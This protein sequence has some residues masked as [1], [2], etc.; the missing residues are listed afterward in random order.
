MK[1]A[2]RIQKHT[3]VQKPRHSTCIAYPHCRDLCRSCRQKKK[4][5]EIKHKV[6]E[7]GLLWGPDILGTV[8]HDPSATWSQ[9]SWNDLK[10][11]RFQSWLLSYWK[12]CGCAFLNRDQMQ[13][14]CPPLTFPAFKR[15][16]P[17]DMEWAMGQVQMAQ[18]TSHNAAWA[19]SGIKDCAL[20]QRGPDRSEKDSDS[21]GWAAIHLPDYME[22][23]FGHHLKTATPGIVITFCK[24]L[25]EKVSDSL[26]TDSLGLSRDEHNTQKHGIQSS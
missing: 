26:K 12:H 17:M 4:M 5:E 9:K 18:P 3:E 6:G 1:N 22:L 13:S 25:H 7:N 19:P 24:S 8:W 11:V 10:C 15:P 20:W 21:K 2:R 23:C 16:K 14:Q